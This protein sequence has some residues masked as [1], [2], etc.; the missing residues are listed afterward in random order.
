M[1]DGRNG[2]L[3]PKENLGM[4]TLI[5]TQAISNGKLSY[6]A[7][8]LASAS[9]D[10]GK[11]LMVSESIESYALL[12]QN[13]VRF[14][15]EVSKPKSIGEIPSNLK[16]EWQWG[17]LENTTNDNH[18][19]SIKSEIG[20]IVDKIEEKWSLNR[21]KISTNISQMEDKAFFSINWAEVRANEKIKARKRLLDEEVSV[22]C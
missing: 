9:K 11:N 5:L 16:D 19:S 1:D 13:V 15:S 12:L 21:S 7:Q 14:P 22:V 18:L 17:V 10:L 6:S 3:F 4:L 8:N 20:F 2:Y